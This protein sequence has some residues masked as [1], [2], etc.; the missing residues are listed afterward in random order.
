[1][2]GSGG[3]WRVELTVEERSVTAL[4]QDGNTLRL[5]LAPVDLVRLLAPEAEGV[6]FTADGADG[7]RYYVEKDFPCIHPRGVEALEPTT[8]TFP[9]PPDFEERKADSAACDTESIE[10]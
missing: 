3:G 9:A 10:K 7:I 2:L 1:M 5:T 6:Y 4:T 8:E